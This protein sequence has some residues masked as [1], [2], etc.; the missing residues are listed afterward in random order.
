MGSLTDLKVLILMGPNVSVVPFGDHTFGIKSLWISLIHLDP[1]FLRFFF[2]EFYT[3]MLSTCNPDPLE[4]NFCI[5]SEVEVRILFFAP[6]CGVAPAPF[7]ERLLSFQQKLHP[8]LSFHPLNCFCNFFRN[9]AGH[10]C[11]VNS[12]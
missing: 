6:E 7:V 2:F 12:F 9:T 5:S 3:F 10:I 8:Y 11:T 4:V 1:N